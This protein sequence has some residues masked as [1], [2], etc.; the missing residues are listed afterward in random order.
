LEDLAINAR[1]ESALLGDDIVPGEAITVSTFGGTVQLGGNVSHAGERM[2][3][4][5]LARDVTGVVDVIN[6]IVVE[7]SS[8]EYRG[9]VEKI[10][11]MPR[12]DRPPGQELDP[13]AAARPGAAPV[14]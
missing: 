1:V 11:R 13:T 2:R 7:S 8:I 4:E 9:P 12:A 6:G 3:A 14:F 5:E 10:Q